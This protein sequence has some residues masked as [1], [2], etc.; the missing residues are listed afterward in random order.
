LIVKIDE[1]TKAAIEDIINR[2]KRAIVTLE[3]TGIVIREQ[4]DKIIYRTNQN[5]D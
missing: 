5:R 2:K 4:S 1:R 3:K